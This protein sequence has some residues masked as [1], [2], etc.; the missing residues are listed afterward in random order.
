MQLLIVH[1]DAEMG[2]QLARM[3][4]DYSA[5]DCEL[6]GNDSAAL[7][8]GRRHAKCALLLTQLDASAIDGLSLGGALSE[9][10]P[11]LQ[12]LFFPG[13]AATDRRLE[14][15]QT[16]VF[17]EPIEGD[18][19]LDAIEE[20]GK[21]P[22]GRPDLFHVVDIIQMCCLGR[23]SGAIQIVRDKRSGLI[24]LRGGQLLH[25]E[26]TGARGADA[27]FEMIEWGRIEFAYDRTVRAPVETIRTQWDEALIEAVTLCKQEKALAS[28]RRA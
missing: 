13:Y 9:I 16:K 19:L 11:G 18:A 25:A 7:E 22:A 24:F 20:A 5:H 3:V 17:P 28:Q 23:R 14:V 4:K 26:T 1:S 27:L 12:T 6:V 15:A 10:F 21:A 8:W 2:E